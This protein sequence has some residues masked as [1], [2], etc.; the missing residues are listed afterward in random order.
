MCFLYHGG[1]T[2]C[3]VFQMWSN[4][5][6]AEGDN[7][8]PWATGCVL[9]TQPSTFLAF[10]ATMAYCWL[11][12]SLLYN[13]AS[14]AWIFSRAVPKLIGPQ[15]VLVPVALLPKFRTW[16]SSLLVFIRFLLSI[17]PT[18]LGAYGWQ[19]CYW[20]YQ[21]LSL[22]WCHLQTSWACILLPPSGHW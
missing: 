3:G 16:H 12:Y 15:P 5:C 6:S 20:V 9:F 17:L 19:P 21:Q 18:C 7:H 13:K 8:F 14:G 22:I 10:F 2:G 4:E 11:M 1:K